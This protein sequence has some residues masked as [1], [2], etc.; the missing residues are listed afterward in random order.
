MGFG[1]KISRT[2]KI[3]RQVHDADA[4]KRE[5]IQRL[6]AEFPEVL[7][8]KND[9][10]NATHLIKIVEL[11][12][13]SFDLIFEN[14]LPSEIERTA[15]MLSGPFF[16][17][18][19]YPIPTSQS[20][21]M[22]PMVQLDLQEVSAAT[23]LPLGD[24]VL[25]LWY[26]SD[27]FV[28]EVRVIPRS[29]LLIEDVTAFSDQIPDAPYVGG[30]WCWLSDTD[31]EVS[32]IVGLESRGIQCQDGYLDMY[33]KY[34]HDQMS[35]ELFEMLM[36]YKKLTEFVSSLHMLGTFYPIQYSAAD[37]GMHCLFNIP[38]W[39]LGGNAEIFYGIDEHGSAD[40]FFSDCVR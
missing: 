31:D 37:I 22:Y 25:Q 10:R 3:A 19:E 26:A 17:C 16:T 20:G 32:Q 18:A 7:L 40:F 4:L 36:K 21:M 28:G 34:L 23:G 9:N 24:G 11:S 5:I 38:N 15:S 6:K 13:E 1:M 30:P 8:E 29:G 33:S 12:A 35:P 39:G 14:H 2:P 27:S